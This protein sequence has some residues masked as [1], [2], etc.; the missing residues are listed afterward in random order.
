MF[1]V[2]GNA[3]LMTFHIIPCFDKLGVHYSPSHRFPVGRCVHK[4]SKAKRAVVSKKKTRHSGV[5][6]RVCRRSPTTSRTSDMANK[7][8]E[9]TCAD[10]VQAI[11]YSDNCGFPVSSTD[12]SKMTG[13]GSKY[14]D[15]FT[16]VRY[17]AR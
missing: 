3:N 7:E 6:S 13:A 10:D 1:L 12:T 11:L 16:E 15:Y 5:G 4:Y 17:A 9:L 2:H 14:S 8:N